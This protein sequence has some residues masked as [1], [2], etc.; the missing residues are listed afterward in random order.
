MLN[1][2]G[3]MLAIVL[4][5]VA[6]MSVVRARSMPGF[7]VSLAATEF[8]SWL[9]GPTLLLV[10]LANGSTAWGIAASMVG[11]ASVVLFLLPV[12]RVAR[13]A[14]DHGL[15]APPL[16]GRVQR[17]H[18]KLENGQSAECFWVA[19]TG[20]KPLIY[21][22]HGGGWEGGGPGEC[23]GFLKK[24]A[25]MGC[26]VVSGS[27]RLAPAHVWPVQRE[28]V[29]AGLRQVLA[30]A[31]ELEIDVN[32]TFVLGRSAGGQIASAVACWDGAPSVSGCICL[33]SPFDMIYAYEHGR[34]DDLLKSPALLRRYLGGTPDAARESYLSASAFHLA[35]PGSPPF[36]LIHGS[37][38]DLV[39]VKQSQRFADRLGEIG[40][41]C[42]YLEFP[43]ATH[44][45][46]HIANG[47]GSRVALAAIHEFVFPVPV[48]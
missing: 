3:S 43:W 45:F 47:P 23:A 5:G 38:D 22:V 39:W 4:L 16:R 33:Y 35:R 12:F 34:E 41:S 24:L 18:L 15:S 29:A 42:R 28:D 30:R 19:G 44:S 25:R 13:F 48:G 32:R 37:R 17:K 20:R 2:A 40:G 7:F 9:A 31:D 11:L 8:G 10:F 36:L 26:V 6:G 14:A 1:V 21:V 27:Y 46:D